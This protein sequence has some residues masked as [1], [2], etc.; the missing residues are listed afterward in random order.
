MKKYIPLANSVAFYY[1][2]QGKKEYL[3]A[4]IEDVL[5]ESDDYE[6]LSTFSVDS[7]VRNYVVLESNSKII[8]LDFNY[9]GIDFLKLDLPILSFL[10]ASSKKPVFLVL[11][12]FTQGQ[13]QVS[14]NIYQIYNN[15]KNSPELSLFVSNS[16]K[17]QQ[18]ADHWGILEY[19]NKFPGYG[20]Q[21]TMEQERIKYVY[22]LLD[23]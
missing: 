23:I 16:L 11:F 22:N 10:K 1:L 8:M 15:K 18:S 19:L 17:K 9:L 14:D 4:I 20:K 6:L 13:N 3:L 7:S 21:Y 5:K 2:W 12:N